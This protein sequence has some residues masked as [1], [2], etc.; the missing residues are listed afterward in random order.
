MKVVYTAAALG[1]LTEIAEWLSVH[2][3]SLAPPRLTALIVLE[4]AVPISKI[5]PRMVP[6][7]AR[8]TDRKTCAAAR[9]PQ[10]CRAAEHS[11][12]RC[13]RYRT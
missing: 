9:K 11:S 3:P 2:Y 12:G 7:A 10:A 1:D 5:D 8:R 6:A 13:V 4:A